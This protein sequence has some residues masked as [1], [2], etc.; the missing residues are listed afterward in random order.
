VREFS[1]VATGSLISH[2]EHQLE[3]NSEAASIVPGIQKL[4]SLAVA[5]TSH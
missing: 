1:A 4:I 2:N 5:L 3:E